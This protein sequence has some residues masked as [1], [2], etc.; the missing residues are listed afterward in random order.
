MDDG[1]QT[2]QR[3]TGNTGPVQQFGPLRVKT[4]SRVP[5]PRVVCR[6]RQRLQG[7][8]PISPAKNPL[9]IDAAIGQVNESDEQ[10]PYDLP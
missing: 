7:H 2:L 5:V 4:L 10:P 6:V 1:E 9:R 3:H 8:H